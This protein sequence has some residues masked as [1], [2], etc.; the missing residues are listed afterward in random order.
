[1]T[2]P[3]GEE[4]VLPPSTVALLEEAAFR[5]VLLGLFAKR[6]TIWRAAWTAITP[7]R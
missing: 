5:G 7:L 3:A 1:M 2:T 4:D 6:T